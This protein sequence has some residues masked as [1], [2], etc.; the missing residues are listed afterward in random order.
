MS[1]PTPPQFTAFCEACQQTIA[2]PSLSSY[3]SVDDEGP[4]VSY[5]FGRCPACARP[6]VM[7]REH[8]SGESDDWQVYPALTKLDLAVPE[9]IRTSFEEARQC[10]RARAFTAAVIMCRRAIEASCAHLGEGQGNLKSKLAALHSRKVLDERLFAWADALRDVGNDAAH[11]AEYIASAEEAR[12]ATEFARAFL[13]N[14]FVIGGR[15]EAFQKR[16][17]DSARV[18]A[19]PR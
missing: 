6:I 9:R 18:A 1:S 17:S 13:E 11:G 15:F 16:R 19:Q 10:L 3:N 12:D 14:L 5:Y 8:Y 7:G 2:V 4:P